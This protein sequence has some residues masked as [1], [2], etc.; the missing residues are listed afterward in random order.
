MG[1][2]SRHCYSVGV[3]EISVENFAVDSASVTLNV[4]FPCT[5]GN[6]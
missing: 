1:G 5:E 2:I 4:L 3:V 6:R